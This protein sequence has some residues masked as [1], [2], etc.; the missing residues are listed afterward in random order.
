[1]SASPARRIRLTFIVSIEVRWLHLEWLCRELDRELFDISFILVC[2]RE[3]TPYL[4]SFLTEHRIPYRRIDCEIGPLSLAKAVGQVRRYCHQEKIEIVSTHMF[5]ADM[6]GLLGAYLARVPVR[7]NTHHH[8]I[9]HR[10]RP[11]IWLNRM[12]KTL[13][14][15]IITASRHAQDDLLTASAAAAGR[16]ILIPFGIDLDRFRTIATERVERLR[17]RY[18]PEGGAPVVGVIARYLEWKGIQY[19][20]PAFRRLLDDYPSAVL[21]LAN[22]RGPY[23]PQIRKALDDLPRDRYREIEFEEDIFALYQ[24]FDVY[25]HAPIGVNFETFGRIYVEA[26]AAGVPTIFTLSGVG[27]EFL[28]HR[29]NTWLVK[30]KDS[31]AIYQGLQALLGNETL[32]ESLVREGRRSVEERFCLRGMIRATT[33]LYLSEIRSATAH[34]QASARSGHQVSP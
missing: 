31:D 33:D 5:L 34:P 10:S 32:C 13:S 8:H 22:A 28:A 12:V 23:R 3:R 9:R 19:V 7:I 6:V 1:M 21:L 27:P 4:Q 15:R 17:R 29:E 24:L 26:L 2:Y 25:V 11:K 20:I 14:T 18:L 30:H 16:S